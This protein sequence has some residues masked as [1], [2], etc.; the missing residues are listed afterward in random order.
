MHITETDSFLDAKPFW[1]ELNKSYKN[2]ELSVDWEIHHQLWERFY[3]DKGYTLKILIG[4]EKRRCVGIIPFKQPST[5]DAQNDWIFGEE[6]IIAREYFAPPNKIHQFLPFF[7]NHNNT[8][9]SCFYTPSV[10]K[11]FVR[12]PGRIVYLADTD[13]AYYNSLS[14]KRRKALLKNERLNSDLN[15]KISPHVDEKE[16]AE[17]TERY[18]QYWLIK[19]ASN[20]KLLEVD[21]REKIEMD[22]FLLKRAEACGKLIALYIYDKNKLIA[23]NFSVR[24]E[25]DRVDDYICMRDTD[26]QYSHRSLGIYAIIENIK[27][28]R[29][30]G[31]RYYDLSDFAADYK[32]KFVNTDMHYFTYS[33]LPF[34]QDN[35]SS[36]FEMTNTPQPQPEVVQEEC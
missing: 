21:S 28:C 24:R 27:Y 3:K 18:I 29:K 35:W 8:D 4:M 12:K 36:P 13:E 25:K 15:V 20:G 2:G 16:I 9:L 33:G 6:T 5:G 23:V 32:M 1:E 30:L 17:L 14:S 19:N 31:I 10:T 26:E 34:T 7:P 11:S 22:L